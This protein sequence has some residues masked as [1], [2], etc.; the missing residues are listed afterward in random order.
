M[1]RPST[2]RTAT[3]ATATRLIT[4]H[5]HD[6][7]SRAASSNPEIVA[8]ALAAT[9][10]RPRSG[11]GRRVG[12]F[13]SRVVIGTLNR[14]ARSAIGS[15]AIE[16]TKIAAAKAAPNAC[17]R[18]G[19]EVATHVAVAATAVP[20]STSDPPSALHSS[21]RP[22]AVCT[23]RP[24]IPRTETSTHSG[25]HREPASAST[26][27][28]RANSTMMQSRRRSTRRSAATELEE[29]IEDSFRG[30][31]VVKSVEL[32]VEQF[33]GSSVLRNHR[34]QVE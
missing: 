9:A 30:M 23:N 16:P 11:R 26:T 15:T 12:K 21:A 24:A 13:G 18:P 29:R 33:P 5:H 2:A 8:T 19:V 32:L 10:T 34:P 7:A 1:A 6:D 14:V 22:G 3:G 17:C 27:P 31:P 25:A 28:T 4:T 20:R